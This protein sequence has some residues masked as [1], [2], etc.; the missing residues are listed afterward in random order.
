MADEIDLMVG[1]VLDTRH[2]KLLETL[3]S[4]LK[5]RRPSV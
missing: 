2:L 1:Y 3:R 5:I 4:R